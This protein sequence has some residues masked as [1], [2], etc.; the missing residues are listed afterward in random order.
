MVAPLAGKRV[1]D[2]GAFCAQRP[3][4][5][6]AAMAARLC[7]AYGA[8]VVRPLPAGGEPLA[9]QPPLLPG[10]GSALDRFLN[11]G[12]RRGPTSGR[13]DMA[14]G[15]SGALE[16][17]ADAVPI[18]ARISVFGPGDDPPMSELGLLALSGLLGIVGEAGGPPARL[19]G[20]QVAYAAGLAACTG[21]LAALRA[22]GE[23]VVDVSLFDVTAWLNWKVAAGVLVLGAAPTRG[24]AR[25]NWHTMPASDGHVALVF[26][27]KDW[28]A[29]RNMLGDER[30]QAPRFATAAGRA[31]HRPEFLSV[32]TPW[33]TARSRAEI[34]AAAQARRI[35]IGPVLAP[36]ELLR[37][38]QNQARGFLA[39][40]G[41]PGLPLSWNG[42]RIQPEAADAA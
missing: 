22:G 6:A 3:H 37:D 25:N 13:F 32:I 40:D 16:A 34:T 23:E 8:E 27:D 20:H 33:F 5:L 31:E 41:T 24:N 18:R 26:Q 1:L 19:A 15:D 39:P 14:I 9:T 28:P 29:L 21:L 42:A 36:V 17:Q 11:A 7:A 35:P 38:P 12:K 10:G 30:L 2:L 4:G